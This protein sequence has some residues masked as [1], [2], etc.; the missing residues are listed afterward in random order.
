V[1]GHVYDTVNLRFN[2]TPSGWAVRAADPESSALFEQRFAQLSDYNTQT[3][4]L[5]PLIEFSLSGK[6]IVEKGLDITLSSAIDKFDDIRH[7]YNL[8]EVQTTGFIDRRYV[9]K[10]NFGEYQLYRNLN[11][12]RAALYSP[13]LINLDIEDRVLVDVAEVKK[14][15]RVETIVSQTNHQ[16][17]VGSFGILATGEL[18]SSFRTIWGNPSSAVSI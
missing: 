15:L 10:A 4:D 17:A 14:T 12:R 9:D 11:E 2:P 16:H 8:P 3:H 6:T 7:I 13:I 1:L 18:R 5:A